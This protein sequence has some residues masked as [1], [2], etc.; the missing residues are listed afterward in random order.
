M[1]NNKLTLFA[2]S[3]KIKKGVYVANYKA[4]NMVARCN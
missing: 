3:D 2:K 1:H 4:I